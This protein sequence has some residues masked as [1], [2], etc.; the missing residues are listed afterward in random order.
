MDFGSRV[1]RV[2]AVVAERGTEGAH[3][4]HVMDRNR[5]DQEESAEH[6]GELKPLRLDDRAESAC[7]D[8]EKAKRGAQDDG[9]GLRHPRGASQQH[10]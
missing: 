8:V 2:G 5:E 10:A 4:P 6:E 9:C 7:A 3:P 1:E